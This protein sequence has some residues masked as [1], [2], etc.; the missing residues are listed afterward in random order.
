M[1]KLGWDGGRLAMRFRGGAEFSREVDGL[2]CAERGRSVFGAYE[3]A[4]WRT[5]LYRLTAADTAELS[6]A[7]GRP[8]H[9]LCL[10][11]GRCRVRH[12]CGADEYEGRYRVLSP[13]QWVV[14]WRV[15]GPRKRQIIASRF[16]RL[17]RP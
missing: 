13:D 15:T 4:A 7:D 17:Q 14:T 8:F 3:G 9:R 1:A 16:T 5:T 11:T 12:R 10:A 6:F 2:V